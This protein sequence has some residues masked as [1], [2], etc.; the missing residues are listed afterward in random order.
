[1]KKKMTQMLLYDE[2]QLFSGTNLQANF[3]CIILT[4]YLSNLYK[5]LSAVVGDLLYSMEI[6]IHFAKGTG[7]IGLHWNDGNKFDGKTWG[8]REKTQ[9]TIR[10]G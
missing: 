3:W 2:L 5:E 9:F 6:K 1:M 4:I 7:L 10:Q 8:L